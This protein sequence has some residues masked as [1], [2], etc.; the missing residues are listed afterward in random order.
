MTK[1]N[2]LQTKDD[3]AKLLGLKSAKYINY[4][5]YNVKTDNLYNS[6]TILKKNG[7]ERVIHAPKKE[8]KF[9]QKKLS[10]VL[11]ECYLESI[12]SKSKDKNFKTPVLSHAFEKGK[13]IITNSQMHRNKKYILNIDLKNFFDS[14]NFGRVR[15]FFIKDKD[16]T[17]SPEIATVIAQ[18]AC[19]Q[20]KLPQGA[21]SSPIITNLITRILDYRIVKIAKKY[22][23]TYSRY[24]D[25]MTFS[26][27]RELN[28][29]KLRASKELDNFLTELEEVIISSG[30]EINPKKTRLSNNMQRQ[31]VTGLVV[32]KKINVK[33]E[34]IKNTRA[35]AFQLYK[36]GAFEIDKKPGT[37]N[38]LTG[39][40]AFIFQIDQYNNYL[41][42]KKSLIQ[43]NLDAQKYL[44]GRNSSKKSES[45]YYW[46]YIFYNKDL[47]KELFDNKK[48]NT[49]NLP[50]EFY[51]IGKEQ[52]KTYMSLFNSREKEYKKF[53]F[54]K[55][56]FGNDKPIIVTEGKTDPR[57]IKAAL[58]KLYRKYPEL[59]EKVGNNFVFK[60][61]F[62]N[63]T[64]TIEYLFNVPEGGEGFKYWYNYFSDKSYYNDEG[65]K[66]FFAL[67]PE[68]RI[69]Y[70]NYITYFQQLTDNIPNYP[71]IFLFD[72]EP[73]NRNGKDKSP[74]FL[75]ANHAKDLMNP[76]NKDSKTSKSLESK[77]SD[78]LEK[79]RREKPCR[80]NKNGSLYIMA[81]PLVSSKN[82]GN[83]SDIEDLLLSRKLPPI[84]KG[85]TFSKSGGD[86]HYGKEI[87]SKHVL[88]N[89]EKFDFT[90]FIPLLDGIR[91]NILDYKSLF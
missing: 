76:Q 42:Y 18:I 82:D 62:L 29:N 30:F 25:D 75:F 87:L 3:F 5:L 43:N 88:K 49:Y 54:Y 48:H 81:T 41:L 63:H 67:D 56:F 70:A 83:F 79:I 69:L 26:T 73:N 23:F 89:Y 59:I 37:I 52:K 31:E 91:D 84:L 38:Q 46:K 9:L 40:F 80:I 13:S 15:G 1:F 28:S 44:L 32:N 61:E 66:K 11:W 24:A 53:L 17:V 12:E 6:F 33:R 60:I 16:F 90:E 4:L 7:G 20:G 57:Y 85:K 72:N 22:R 10:N 78:N 65:K 47:R 74:L 77:I 8:L 19:Y 27:N 68:E 86:N 64:N 39:R 14:F 21:P 2:Q 34:Y 35:M 51:S 45:K 55:Y 50:T 58:K 36:D 71:T